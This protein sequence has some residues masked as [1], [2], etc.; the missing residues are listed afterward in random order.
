M[1]PASDADFPPDDEQV[2]VLSFELADDRYCVRTD[3]VA[4]VRGLA[5]TAP[6][7][8]AVDPWNAGSVL[9]GDARVR[10]VDLPRIVAGVTQTTARTDDPML[11]VLTES[12]DSGA[13]FGWL[14]D[15]VDV[16]RTV[17]TSALEATQAPTRFILGRFEFDDGSAML[18]DETAIHD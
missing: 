17:H 8:D 2:P 12:D 6:L 9:V 7:E 15:G 13:Y 3:A 16:T 5:E 11:L 14:V 1:T 18:L 4:T 10:V